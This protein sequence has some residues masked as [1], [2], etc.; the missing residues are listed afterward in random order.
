MNPRPLWDPR[1]DLAPRLIAEEL[2][3]DLS[4]VRVEHGPP[5]GRLYANP[6]PGFQVPGGS[7]SVRGAWERLRRAGATARPMLVSAAAQTWKVDENLTPELRGVRISAAV[8]I[9]HA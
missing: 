1:N 7:M 6:L 4:Q 8:R 3:A 9:S 2:E 5:S